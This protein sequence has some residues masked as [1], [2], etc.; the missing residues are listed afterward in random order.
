[1]QQILQQEKQLHPSRDMP[2]KMFYVTEEQLDKADNEMTR[3]EV[4]MDSIGKLFGKEQKDVHPV[5]KQNL[6]GMTLQQQFTEDYEVSWF[7]NTTDYEYLY[8][9]I[10]GLDLGRNFASADLC[11]QDDILV[12]VDDI[13]HFYNNFT[14]EIFFTEVD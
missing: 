8:E 12:F 9:F 7:S 5:V 10:Q 2:E 1:M 14:E 4:I 6:P 11:V 3:S 13:V